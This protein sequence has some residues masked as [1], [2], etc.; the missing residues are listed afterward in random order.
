MLALSLS[1]ACSGDQPA[2]TPPDRTSVQ[3]SV[4]ATAPASETASPSAGESDSGPDT[5]PP[6]VK[7]SSPPPDPTAAPTVTPAQR[8]KTVKNRIPAKAGTFREGVRWSDG[9]RLDVVAIVSSTQSG[10]GRGSQPGSPQTT[11]ALELTNGSDKTVD[12]RSV[13]VTTTYVAG[14]TSRI[15]PPVYGTSTQDFGVRLKPTT[16]A[17]AKYAFSIPKKR[18]GAVTVT[19]DLDATHDLARFTGSAR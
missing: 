3:P 11:F 7:S 16:N 12:A 4:A 2:Q 14:S 13:V 17:T 19:V 8:S 5:K 9:L 15:A 6:S 1:T 10:R 18:L